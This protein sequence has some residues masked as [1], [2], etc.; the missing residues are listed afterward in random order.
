MKMK[1]TSLVVAWWLAAMAVGHAQPSDKEM[2]TLAASLIRALMSQ[3]SKNVAAVDFTDLQGQPTELGRYLSEQLSV[4]MVLAG[5]VSMLDRAHIR[6]ILAEHKLTEEGLVNPANA[7]KLGEFAGVDT[8]LIGTVTAVDSGFVLMVKGISTESA[9]LV[10]A[11][12]ITIPRTPD[13]Q[14]FG[15]RT[16]RDGAPATTGGSDRPTYQPA[17]SIASK[18]VGPLRFALTSVLPTKIRDQSNEER[19]GVRVSIDLT[20]RETQRHLV[21][22]INA[23]APKNGPECPSCVTPYGYIFGQDM[24]KLLRATLIDERGGAWEL[25]A[26]RVTG[27]DIVGVGLLHRPAEIVSLLQRPERAYGNDSG[28]KGAWGKGIPAVFG[29]TTDIAP[30][31]T[32]RLTMEFVQTLPAQAASIS[33]HVFQFSGEFVV[34][35]VEMNGSKSYSL[36][37]VIFDSISPPR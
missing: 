3:G 19:F 36:Q 37:N 22:A 30:G 20:S 9:K 33:A 28:D 23:D 25:P 13:L 4:E 24:G 18:D 5:G 26:A 2:A 11:G 35:V 10:G 14:G 27:I 15:N 17:S 6:S 34:G 7:K 21:A 12:R 29:S 32:V 16:L 31:Q 1:A 8:I